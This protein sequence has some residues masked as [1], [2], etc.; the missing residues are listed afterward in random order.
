[1]DTALPTA[2]TARLVTLPDGNDHPVVDLPYHVLLDGRQLQGRGLSLVAA[3]VAGRVDAP[4]A[5]PPRLVRLVFDFDGFQIALLVEAT[6]H[7][8][9]DG[10]GAALIFTN[11][12]GPHLPQLRHVLNAYIAGDLVSLGQSIG[13]AGT[14]AARL[15]A[16]FA[17]G[18]AH[19]WDHRIRMGAVTLAAVALFGLAGMLIYQRTFVR[20]LPDL[21]IVTMGSETLL[22][23]AAGQIVFLDAAAGNGAV[24]LAIQASN[25]E[26]L[27]LTN[28]CDCRVISLGPQ[29]G[30][31]V[32]LGDAVVQL[33]APGDAVVV[34]TMLDPATVFAL[35]RGDGLE[36]TL[37][38]GTTRTARL[39]PNGNAALPQHL[40][41]EPVL[42]P[43]Q[44]GQPVQIRILKQTGWLG[45]G[46]ASLRAQFAFAKKAL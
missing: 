38:D 19:G 1:M 9:E 20:L 17:A 10:T 15:P 34:Q 43:A 3:Y 14:A 26:V 16:G 8:A 46:L 4:H 30:S 24:I 12:T 45:T 18:T 29:T 13:V 35:G 36:L 5:G 2:Q 6:I 28:P 40:L 32:L 44:I 11:P 33:A 22:A 7:P 25:G 39:E 21:G 41:A 42:D 31:T 37:P 27:S 23:T